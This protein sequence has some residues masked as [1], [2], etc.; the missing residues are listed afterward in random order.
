[1]TMPIHFDWQ[2]EPL[3]PLPCFGPLLTMGTLTMARIQITFSNGIGFPLRMERKLFIAQMS[4]QSGV[5]TEETK[6]ERRAAILF[7]LLANRRN[8]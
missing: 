4:C 3:K 6:I 8:I 5:G 2:Q 1:M 7:L